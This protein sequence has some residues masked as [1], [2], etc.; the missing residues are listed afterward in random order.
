[1]SETKDISERELLKEKVK[2]VTKSWR[3]D[4]S[5]Q[6][7][8]F[9]IHPSIVDSLCSKTSTADSTARQYGYFPV[10]MGAN[11]R[12]LEARIEKLLQ[13]FH[14]ATNCRVSSMLVKRHNYANPATDYLKVAIYLEK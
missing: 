2:G 7:A 5:E 9:F 1:M 10:D 13:E 11:I 4:E 3:A 14:T 6:T 12:A 8:S